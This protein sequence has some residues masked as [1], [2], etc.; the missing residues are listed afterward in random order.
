ML[1]VTMKKMMKK[2]ICLLLFFKSHTHHTTRFHSQNRH[3]HRMGKNGLN[4]SALNN[5]GFKNHNAMCTLHRQANRFDI[6]SNRNGFLIN[7]HQMNTLKLQLVQR[8]K[9]QRG[10]QHYLLLHKKP[11]L[12]LLIFHSSSAH[13]VCISERRMNGTKSAIFSLFY[14]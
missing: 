12:E 10:Q 8:S 14:C 5:N 7:H 2:K 13:A 6:F 11:Y 3:V 4:F 1:C 9:S